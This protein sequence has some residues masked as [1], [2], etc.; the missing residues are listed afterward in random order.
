[1]RSALVFVAVLMAPLAVAAEPEIVSLKKLNDDPS[2]YKDKSVRFHAQISG[3][4]AE[5]RGSVWLTVKD[6][7]VLIEGDKVNKDG[8]NIIIRKKNKN[9]LLGKLS[10]EQFINGT[11]TATIRQPRIL[12]LAV[13]TAI[14]FEDA[15][16]NSKGTQGAPPSGPTAKNS[17]ATQEASPTGPVE[18]WS[19]EQLLRR[20]DTA[21]SDNKVA[22]ELDKRSNGKRF[23]IFKNDRSV[24]VPSS[25]FLFK[26]LRKGFSER[27]WF[28]VDGYLYKTYKVGVVPEELFDE[29]PL[30][31]GEPLRLDG[32]CEHT[33]RMWKGV[34]LIVRQVLY[35]AVTDSKELLIAKAA[36]AQ[37]VLDQLK[38]RNAADAEKWVKERYPRAFISYEEKKERNQLPILKRTFEPKKEPKTASPKGDK[39][40]ESQ[41]GD[42]KEEPRKENKS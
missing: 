29:N 6:G 11:I 1:M 25:E 5:K 14:D 20:Y 41:T 39:K 15:P 30:Y 35:L 38:D 34:P 10:Q 32:M 16:E 9:Q 4:V 19:L 8:I 23:L 2:L 3:N 21:E 22:R 24:D 36:D 28:E 31:P 27:D 7:M 40:E 18:D 13:V 37:Y 12:W 33:Q 17:T 42:K 26:E